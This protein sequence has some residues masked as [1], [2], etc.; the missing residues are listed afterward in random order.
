M[1]SARCCVSQPE[2]V[3]GSQHHKELPSPYPESLSRLEP[4]ESLFQCAQP[5]FFP[6]LC[7]STSLLPPPLPACG[8]LTPA[9]CYRPP[10]FWLLPPGSCLLAPASSRH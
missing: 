8:R 9:T 7:S 10:A 4:Q 3:S 6:V 2:E 5:E 1:G